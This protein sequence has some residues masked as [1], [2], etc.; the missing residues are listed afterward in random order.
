M[1]R[2]GIVLTTYKNPELP[3]TQIERAD[4][5]KEK[6]KLSEIHKL[7]VDR[8]TEI[9]HVSEKRASQ[10]RGLAAFQQIPSIGHKLAEKVVYMLDIHT[11]EE[12]KDEKGADLVDRLE[13]T[14]GVWMDPCVEDQVRCVI[15]YANKPDS[16]KQWFDFTE[17][18]KAYRQTDG[19]PNSRPKKAWYE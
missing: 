13:K 9:L 3:L 18:R 4:L 11:L 6:V 17:E 1:K 14:M 7:E 10:I 12:L 8:L 5:R 2:G 15:H 16:N 19:Y